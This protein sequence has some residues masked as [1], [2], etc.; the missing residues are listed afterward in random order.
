MAVQCMKRMTV[1]FLVLVMIFMISACGTE[2]VQTSADP[3]TGETAAQET[4]ATE[5][6][7]IEE[8]GGNGLITINGIYLDSSMSTEYQYFIYVVY[9]VT[10]DTKEDVQLPLYTEDGTETSAASL[11]VGDLE[12]Y[13]DLYPMNEWMSEAF[14]DM[15]EP[16][17]SPSDG[18]VIEHGSSAV[19]MVS[20][21]QINTDNISSDT[22]LTLHF[23]AGDFDVSDTATVADIQTVASSS[24]IPVL[25]ATSSSSNS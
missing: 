12:N 3:E 11:T 19:R 18:S 17:R 2:E 23:T 13:T 10:N 5:T 16:Y 9:D 20:C 22:V 15:E 25:I 4:A 24:E 1:L 7:D 14:A 21:F 6:E 8:I